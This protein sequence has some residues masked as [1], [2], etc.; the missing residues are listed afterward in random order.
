MA[1]K[2]QRVY[3]TELYVLRD[4]TFGTYVGMGGLH[5]GLVS[6][7]FA[8]VYSGNILQNMGYDWRRSFRAERIIE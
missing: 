5:A 7:P 8:R 3:G 1:E 4:R 6:H 2:K